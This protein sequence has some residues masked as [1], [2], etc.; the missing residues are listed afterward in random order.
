MARKG[1]IS[2][3]YDLE[4]IQAQQDKVIGFVNDFV[5]KISEAKPIAIK[6][7][8]AE[9]TKD[10]VDGIKQVNQSTETMVRMTNLAVNEYGKLTVLAKSYAGTL[11]DQKT[12]LD[13]V[14]GTFEQNIQLQ[15]RYKATLDENKKA[16]KDLNA[17]YQDGQVSADEYSQ[18]MVELNAEQKQLQDANRQLNTTLRNQARE[19]NAAEGSLEQMRARLNQLQQVF[20]TMSDEDPLRGFFQGEIDKILPKIKALEGGI[21]QFGRNVGNYA[22]AFTP[23]FQ[24]LTEQLD[25]VRSKLSQM[26]QGDSGFEQLKREEQALGQFTENLNKQFTSSKQE[27][28]AFQE[29]AVQMGITLGDTN[30]NFLKFN[31]AVGQG[32]NEINDLKAATKLQASDTKYIDG[33]VSGAQAL[34]GT[35]GIAQ[36]ATELFGG[37][38]DELAKKMVKLQAI[39][40]ILNGLQAV[41]NA[42]QTESGAV[43]LIL[44]AKTNV[45][46][47][48]KRVETALFAQT[49]VAAEAEAVAMAENA[50]ATEA[51]TVA[52]GGN[53]AAATASTV[54]ME[55]EAVAAETA[56]VATTQLSTATKILTTVGVVGLVAG[57]SIPDHKTGG[58]VIQH[59]KH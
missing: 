26:S 51:A 20:I 42:L 47:I 5:N 58:L 38:T 59:K 29:A 50:A 3:L 32:L 43:Q 52:Q 9:K 36:G 44:A 19:F 18:K 23:A 28:R 30:E 39:L 22:S 12:V 34:A 57:C 15:L 10:V 27:L 35:Y 16:Q 56:T 31:Q 53:A 45:L 25:Q 54:A 8:G 4:R 40:T 17:A 2:D 1:K 46:N 6:L 41:Q 24:M 11:S 55:G 13:K 21:G 48:A 14:N 33:L 49:A 7:E 37:S